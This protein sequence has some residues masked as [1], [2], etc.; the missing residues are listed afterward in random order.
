MVQGYGK[1]GPDFAWDA[2]HSLGLGGVRLESDSIEQAHQDGDR[3]VEQLRVPVC[4]CVYVCVNSATGAVSAPRLLTTRDSN[5]Y[6][7]HT[8]APN[9]SILK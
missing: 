8:L 9:T 7:E 4:V 2:N 1:T 6:T 5:F 3:P